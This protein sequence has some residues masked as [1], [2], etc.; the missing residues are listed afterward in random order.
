MRMTS[1]CERFEA[2]LAVTAERADGAAAD[3]ALT[4]HLADCEACGSALTAQRTIRQHLVRHRQALQP[5]VPPGVRTRLAAKL[6]GE[7]HAE[8]TAP[9]WGFRL[10]PLAAAAALV[11]V[12][13]VGL[14]PVVTGQSSVVLAAQLAL[15]HVKCFLIDGDLHAEPVTAAEAE[16]TIRQQHGWSVRVSESGGVDDSRLVAVRECLYGEGLA[17]HLLY[18]VG[19]APVSL[20]VMPTDNHVV[21]PV[22]MLAAETV[23]WNQN[24]HTHMLVGPAGSRATLDS[25][26]QHLQHEAR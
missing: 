7:A 14:L 25:M 13:T 20:F 2:R 3:P 21:A 6:A 8:A 26:A 22:S 5:T 10:S 19:N 17:A 12:V 16:A 11:L 18:R 9:G 24:G 4:A 23:S 15:D 1:E